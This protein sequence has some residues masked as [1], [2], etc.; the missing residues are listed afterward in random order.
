MH[1]VSSNNASTD[2][3]PFITFYS[4]VDNNPADVLVTRPARLDNRREDKVYKPRGSICSYAIT[5]KLPARPSGAALGNC[6]LL[7]R[8]P[9]ALGLRQIA[10]ADPVIHVG[11]ANGPK[12]LV[13][14]ADAPGTFLKL[15]AELVQRSQVVGS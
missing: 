13:V 15:F 2:P 7:P 6:G 3:I 4:S 9:G 11:F 14:E 8:T 12:P 1:P 10:V 5:T